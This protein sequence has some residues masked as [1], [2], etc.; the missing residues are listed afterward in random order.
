MQRPHGTNDDVLVPRHRM[1]NPAPRPKAQSERPSSFRDNQS[2]PWT[3]GASCRWDFRKQLESGEWKYEFKMSSLTT[4]ILNLLFAEAEQK[5]QDSHFRTQIGPGSDGLSADKLSLDLK[6]NPWDTTISFRLEWY[7]MSKTVFTQYDTVES[8]QDAWLDD[9]KTFSSS[10][11]TLSDCCPSVFSSSPGHRPVG[12]ICTPLVRKK[13]HRRLLFPPDPY[14]D[15][16]ATLNRKQ[17]TKHPT[18][19]H[20][21][22]TPF[23]TV[24]QLR[25]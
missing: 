10:T 21:G 25:T 13:M 18:A 20:F 22:P 1:R 8:Q 15:K 17:T 12:G 2:F 6:F 23:R 14:K 19:K 4:S 16:R 9:V 11:T 3:T 24:K 5:K 7:S